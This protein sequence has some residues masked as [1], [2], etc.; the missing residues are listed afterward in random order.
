MKETLVV[1]DVECKTILIDELWYVVV[2][3]VPQQ[4]YRAWVKHK[5]CVG[6]KTRVFKLK[7]IC[8]V[9]S[10]EFFGELGGLRKYC[11]HICRAKVGINVLHSK[12]VKIFVSK[13]L[14]IKA[15]SFIANAIRDEKIIRP[16]TCSNCNCHGH[17]SP[18]HPNYEKKNEVIWLCYSCHTKLHYGNKEVKGELVVY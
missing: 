4:L 9:C 11:S 2:V 1:N 15:Q 7:S 12:H 17:V 6:G 18:H 13:E 8:I 16:Q 5:N 14:K 3:G 10:K